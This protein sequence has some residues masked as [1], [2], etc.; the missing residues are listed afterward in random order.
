MTALESAVVTWGLV[1]AVGIGLALGINSRSR[2]IDKA[3]DQID[4]KLELI[5]NPPTQ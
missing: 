2:S 4:Q 1:L 3:L 5:L